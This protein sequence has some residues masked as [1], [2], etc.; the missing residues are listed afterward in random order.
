MEKVQEGFKNGIIIGRFQVDELTDGH[1]DLI[2]RVANTHERTIIILGLSPCKCTMSNP[3][4]FQ[5]RKGMIQEVFPDVEVLYV[6]DVGSD[7]LWSD[8]VDE[9]LVKAGCLTEDSC[10]Y[11][12]RDSFIPHYSGKF[13]TQV[14][15]QLVF[16]SGTQRRKELAS[17]IVR[18]ADFRKG[19]IWGMMNQYP[20]AYSTVDVAIFNEYDTMILLGRKDQEKEY[21]FIGGFT[22]PGETHED[23]ASREAKEEAGIDVKN[24]DYVKSFVIDDWRY[25]SEASKITTALFETYE[26][27]GKPCPGDDIFELRWFPFNKHTVN[28]VVDAHKDMFKYLLER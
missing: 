25:R 28:H 21:R 9:L 3:L 1:K 19:V 17:K 6:Y 23:A 12:S 22:A 2:S 7:L 15:E 14:L 4:D 27:E 10:L 18:N 16:S 11:G 5:S 20:V 24:M 8:T 26:W 13:K